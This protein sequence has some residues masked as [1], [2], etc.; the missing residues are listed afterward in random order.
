MEQKPR[1]SFNSQELGKE[2][3][4]DSISGADRKN[5]DDYLWKK[6]NKDEIKAF[7]YVKVGC[8]YFVPLLAAVTIAVF[9]LNK[10]LPASRRWL[11][12]AEL[13]DLQTLCVSIISGVATTLVVNYFYKNK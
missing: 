7:H 13:S 4:E 10:L 2:I 9:F 11:T 12:P 6:Y 5:G 1:P 8:I 3:I